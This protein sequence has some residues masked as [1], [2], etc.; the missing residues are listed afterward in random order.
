M[1]WLI[2]MIIGAG[3]IAFAW[4]QGRRNG[5]AEVRQQQVEAAVNAEAKRDEMDAEIAEDIDLADRAKRAG[6]VRRED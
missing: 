3:A 2:G 6:L 4:W 5:R 1:D